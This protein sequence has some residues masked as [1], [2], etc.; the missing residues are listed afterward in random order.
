MLNKNIKNTTKTRQDIV[1]ALSKYYHKFDKKKWEKFQ[2]DK[3]SSIDKD[4]QKIWKKEHGGYINP[5]VLSSLRNKNSSMLPKILPKIVL[6]EN[7]FILPEMAS[8]NKLFQKKYVNKGNELLLKLHSNEPLIIDL[9]N[10]NGGKPE[11]MAAALLPLF[12]L[13]NSKILTYIKTK[14]GSHKKDIVRSGNCIISYV[15]NKSKTCGTKKQLSSTPPII[16]ILVNKQTVGTA[17]QMAIALKILS[18]VTTVEI[19]GEKTYGYTTSNKYIELSDKGGLDIPYGVMTDFEKNAYPDGVNPSKS[20]YKKG[21]FNVNG[22]NNSAE[23]KKNDSGYN[24]SNNSHQIGRFKVSYPSNNS[25]SSKNRYVQFYDKNHTIDKE[26]IYNSNHRANSYNKNKKN[27]NKQKKRNFVVNDLIMVDLNDKP[28]GDGWMKND[29]MH[30]HVNSDGSVTYYN[31]S[32]SNKHYMGKSYYTYKGNNYTLDNLKK[33][34]NSYLNV[35]LSDQHV[36]NG[37]IWKI[38]KDGYKYYPRKDGLAIVLNKINEND[39]HYAIMINKDGTFIPRISD[40][41]MMKMGNREVRE[42]V[43]GDKYYVINGIIYREGMNGELV[44]PYV[45]Q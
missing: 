18:K 22:S 28:I 38:S 43:N 35:N 37:N 6:S 40:K 1:K 25:S 34:I 16:I 33:N 29:V 39:R 10:N 17:E 7:K 23:L 45:G 27:N 24:S 2:S 32:D 13:V 41:I 21:G 4:F 36:G 8:N 14:N 3:S 20:I 44:R 12:N 5:E 11:V 19:V 30:Y 15:N 26:I 9:R 42:T 31:L